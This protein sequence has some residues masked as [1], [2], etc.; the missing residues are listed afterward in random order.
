MKHNGHSPRTREHGVSGSGRVLVRTVT[1]ERSVARFDAPAAGK[2]VT[3][4]VTTPRTRAW[5]NYL[6]RASGSDC[7]TVGDTVSCT[8][9]ADK[10]FIQVVRV[11]VTLE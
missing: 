4:N 2:D 6:S 3:I 1:P 5:S 10:V 11:D 7:T 8:V 9:A